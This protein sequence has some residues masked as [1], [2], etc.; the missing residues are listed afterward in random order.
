MPGFP[1]LYP[2]AGVVNQRYYAYEVMEDVKPPFWDGTSLNLPPIFGWGGRIGA[3]PPQQ[4]YPGWLNINR[5]QD[6]SI[7]L[8]KVMG[9]HTMKAG[10]YNNHSFKAQNVGAGG[11][12]NLSFQGFV[13][14]GN[15]VNNPLDAGFGYANA[16]TGVFS[17][18]LQASNFVEGSMIYNN[19]EF[20][21][22][23]NWKVNSRLTLDYGMRFTRQQPQY[24]Q[25]QQMSNFFTDRWNPRRRRCSTCRA[26]SAA[27]PRARATR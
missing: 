11:I 5:T 7:S 18:Y 10:F 14:F 23:D 27:S 21:L 25:F 12:A 22:Q 13:N 20:Y 26:A 24:D 19:T 3:A 1:M 6:V 16:Y 15:D 4:R 17:Q 9:R 8:T 2:Q